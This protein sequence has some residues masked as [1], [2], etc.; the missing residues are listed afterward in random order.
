MTQPA[1]PFQRR[2]FIKG[3][4]LGLIAGALADASPARSA[5]EGGEIGSGEYWAKKGDVPLWMFRKRVGAPKA[6]EATRPVVFFVHLAG[7]ET[8]SVIDQH[9]NIFRFIQH[10]I[11]KCF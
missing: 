4:G 8:S 3:A 11:S 9:I 10:P 6:G 1:N 2:T 5:G 7:N